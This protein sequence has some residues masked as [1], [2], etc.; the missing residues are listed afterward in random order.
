MA[1]LANYPDSLYDTCSDDSFEDQVSAWGGS[2]S[3]MRTQGKL[4]FFCGKMA[5][6]KSTLA[7]KLADQHDAILLI[8]DELLPALFPGEITSIPA[9]VTCYSR[10]KTALAPC[11]C[12]LLS[13][14]ICV[15]LDFAANTKSQRA[16]FRELIE[17][18]GIEHELHVVEASDELCKAQLASRSKSLP[19]G[20]PW[21]TE[22]EFEAITAYFQPPSAEEKFNVIRH[23]RA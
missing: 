17:Q 22:S 23:E 3:R 10:L 5:S 15:V 20:T 18:A 11:I 19:P 7:R 8:Q 2:A 9:F 16:W 4:I 1:V 14:G 12:A 21:T 6:G 13:R